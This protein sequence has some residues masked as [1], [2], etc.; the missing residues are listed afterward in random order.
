MKIGWCV[1]AELAPAEPAIR[2]AATAMAA[3][4]ERFLFIVITS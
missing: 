4:A 2:D 3:S 1:V